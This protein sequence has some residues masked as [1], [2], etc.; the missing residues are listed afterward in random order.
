LYNSTGQVNST[1]Y[2]DGTR[3]INWTSLPDGTYTY[4]VTVIDIAENSNTTSTRT[5]TLDT[6]NPTASPSCTPS[7]VYVNDVVTCR[8]G[9]S[10]GG[11]SGINSALTTASST[12]STSSSGTF[13][14]SCSVTD[15]AGNT[16]SSPTTYVVNAVSSGGGS[17]TTSF[18]KST[19]AISDEEFQNS[20]TKQ[21][22]KTERIRVSVNNEY[23]YVGVRELT[24]TSATIEITS[25]PVQV[26]L[27]IGQDAK[28][29][30]TDDGYYDIYVLLNSITGGKA[31]ITIKEINEEIPEGESVVSTTGE[32]VTPKEGGNVEAKSYN[33]IY[34]IVGIIIVLIV[35]WFVISKKR[36][37]KEYF[38]KPQEY[39]ST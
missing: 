26:K 24:E 27:E 34:W 39:I 31:E 5:L 4:N 9:G 32:E 25:E 14:Y 15:Y 28:F 1:T 8:C 13:T 36:K 17:S 38:N 30:V 18:W 3:T 22:S 19:H 20:Y 12:P 35:V 6:T 11:G 7:S 29:D 16:A 37:N 10:D 2:T 33:W 23:H 21:L